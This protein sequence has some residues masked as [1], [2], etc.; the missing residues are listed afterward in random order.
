MKPVISVRWIFLTDCLWLMFLSTFVYLR[1][2][3]YSNDYIRWIV[4]VGICGLL[5]P[6]AFI[7]TS[8]LK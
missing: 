4:I 7:D 2:G 8:S 1:G 3:S 5:A 6:W